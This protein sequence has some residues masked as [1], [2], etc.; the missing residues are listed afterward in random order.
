MLLKQLKMRQNNKKMDFLGTL[1][2]RLLR[3][4]L[5]GKGTIKAGEITIKAGEGKIRAGQNV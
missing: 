4:P 1:V 3:N 2:A 5:I